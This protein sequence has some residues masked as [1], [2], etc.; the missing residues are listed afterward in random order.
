MSTLQQIGWSSSLVDKIA[1]FATEGTMYRSMSHIGSHEERSRRSLQHELEAIGQLKLLYCA[2]FSEMM[3]EYVTVHTA[4]PWSM[5]QCHLLWPVTCH[6]SA[7]CCGVASSRF[8]V[9]P[10]SNNFF[11]ISKVGSK[12]F[13]VVPKLVP[14]SVPCS[15]LMRAACF[16]LTYT[17]IKSIN[18]CYSMSMWGRGE[19]DSCMNKWLTD[20]LNCSWIEKW[21]IFEIQHLSDLQSTPPVTF[22]PPVVDILDKWN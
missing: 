16:S 2:V 14:R 19:S 22:W 17:W 5:S 7:A 21:D 1:P 4:S 15:A 18:Q 6:P 3:N 12:L 9:V 20:L 13:Q 10:N 8:Y 11:Q